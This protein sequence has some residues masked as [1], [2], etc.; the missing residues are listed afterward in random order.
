MQI[1]I[2]HSTYLFKMNKFFF[3]KIIK[4]LYTIIFWLIYLIYL[5]ILD[6]MEYKENDLEYIFYLILNPLFL[7]FLM[8]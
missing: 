7:H 5:F 3:L 8:K 4:E 1:N 2:L 6:L